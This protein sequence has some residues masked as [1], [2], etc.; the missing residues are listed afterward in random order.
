MSPH[1]TAENFSPRVENKDANSAEDEPK[2]L[3]QTHN[4]GVEGAPDVMLDKTV[5]PA[6]AKQDDEANHLPIGPRLML[7][8]ASLMLGVF[9]MALDNNVRWFLEIGNAS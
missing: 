3:H 9:C 1:S 8:V 6:V 4:T 5:E 7:I 2:E